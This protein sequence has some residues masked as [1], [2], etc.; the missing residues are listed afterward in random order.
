MLARFC[1]LSCLHE[2]RPADSSGE[3]KAFG[4]SRVVV[5]IGYAL[6]AVLAIPALILALLIGGIW[7]AADRLAARLE[8][9][10]K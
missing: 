9:K 6:I 2:R 4:L 1:Q 7:T 10:D 8:K 3:N 5:W